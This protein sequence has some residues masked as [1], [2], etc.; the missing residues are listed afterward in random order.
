[1]NDF[2]FLIFVGPSG[3]GKTTIASK[4]KPL[5]VVEAIS[6]TTRTPRPGEVDGVHYHFVSQTTFSD[7]VISDAFVEYATYGNKSYGLTTAD[8]HVAVETSPIR[9]AACVMEIN[10]FSA[11][12]KRL[13]DAVRGIFVDC[14]RETAERRLQ[15]RGDLTDDLLHQ[16]LSLYDVEYKNRSLFTDDTS[17]HLHVFD[18]HSDGIT[19]IETLLKE[20]S[21]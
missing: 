18:N 3:S 21:K 1:M 2:R 13:P 7:L 6:T 12:R 10:G 11:A 8:L 20:W 17:G 16:R 15:S 5:G 19:D 4:L 14:N 9:V